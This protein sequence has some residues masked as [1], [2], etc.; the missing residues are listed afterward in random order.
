[1]AGVAVV[2]LGMFGCGSSL[3]GPGTGTG[4]GSGGGNGTGGAAGVA[5]DGGSADGPARDAPLV[6]PRPVST[7]TWA[8]VLATPPV[9]VLFNTAETRSTCGDYYVDVFSQVES[10][11][12]YYYDKST[13]Q[14]VAQY[15][16]GAGPP[17]GGG[18][19]CI[20]GPPGG[21]AACL[22]SF[23]PGGGFC[24]QDGGADGVHQ[25]ATAGDALASSG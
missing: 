14:L 8:G 19:R 5:T 23:T 11:T 21:I 18:N 25:D 15:S 13:G 22:P 12:A 4:G 7:A 17:E 3:N 2:A 24:P 1:M 10:G 6:C 9:C 16:F 20:A